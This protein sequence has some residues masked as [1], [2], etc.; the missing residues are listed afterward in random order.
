MYSE[1]SDPKAL[2]FR[3]LG[4]QLDVE[5]CS[6]GKTILRTSCEEVSEVEARVVM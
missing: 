5:L 6:S 4:T 2:V 1:E 3:V